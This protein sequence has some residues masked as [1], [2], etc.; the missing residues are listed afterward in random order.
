M[1]K[2]VVVLRKLLDILPMIFIRCNL[3]FISEGSSLT[4]FY[5]L[6]KKKITFPEKQKFDFLKEKKN[7]KI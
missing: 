6:V 3:L 7:D 1:T 5:Y 2:E 4:D